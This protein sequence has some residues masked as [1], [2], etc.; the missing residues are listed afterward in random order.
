[1]GLDILI[2]LR[3]KKMFRYKKIIWLI[4]LF[5]LLTGGC[6]RI[7]WWYFSPN[8]S[9]FPLP[10]NFFPETAQVSKIYDSRDGDPST[11]TSIQNIFFQDGY[12]NGKFD[13]AGYSV[14]EFHYSRQAKKRF[15][16]DIAW[17]AE[18]HDY[19]AI[20]AE[21]N[22]AERYYVACGYD[23]TESRDCVF[24]GQYRNFMFFFSSNVGDFFTLE[25]FLDVVY[26]IDEMAGEGIMQ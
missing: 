22:W 19:D 10:E 8:P 5:T 24:Q 18:K 25:E 13:A 21:I 17:W 12:V 23:I 4:S 2:T 7:G 6:V 1:M 20:S 16:S 3:S 15:E 11:Q 26:Y 9:D 14:I